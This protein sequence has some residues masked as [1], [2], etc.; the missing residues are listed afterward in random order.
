M[1]PTDLQAAERDLARL[2]SAARRDTTPN[3]SGCMVWHRW[4]EPHG[5]PVVLLHG[6]AGSWRH[7]VRNIASLAAE[8][9][10]LAGDIPGL[11]ASDMPPANDHDTVAWVIADGILQLSESTGP[12]HLV[13][14]SFGGLLAGLVAARA[15]ALVKTLTIL[16][17]GTLGLPRS[18]TPLEKIS[19]KEGAVRLA[20]HRANLASLMIADPAKIDAMALAIQ[21]WN[22]RHARLRQRP[23][24][25]TAPLRDALALVRAPLTAIYGERD[26]TAYP[27]VDARAALMRRLQPTMT[28]HTIPA[29]GHWVAYEAPD[30]V[31]GLL[32]KTIAKH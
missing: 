24:P 15:P 14:F 19:G 4:G 28:F 21:D 29:A 27:H 5:A 17:S 31:N 10:V 3:G 16:G 30:E 23:A 1:D 6:G 9:E 18:P 32:Q 13:G 12:V 2:E 26:A 25:D 11:G 20:A 7:W 8:R 22:T